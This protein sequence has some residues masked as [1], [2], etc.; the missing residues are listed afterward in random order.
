MVRYTLLVLVVYGCVTT[1]VKAADEN[2]NLYR[3]CLEFCTDKYSDAYGVEAIKIS[4]EVVR[5]LCRRHR[6]DKIEYLNVEAYEKQEDV[7]VDV[8]AD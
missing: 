3:V 2:S 6:G 8:L 4:P 7:D 5:C 1:G